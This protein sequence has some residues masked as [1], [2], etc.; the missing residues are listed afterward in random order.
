MILVSLD[1]I[2]SN[3]DNFREK[4]WISLENDMN[5]LSNNIY[6]A[7]YRKYQKYSKNLEAFGVEMNNLTQKIDSSWAEKAW[8]DYMILF[9]KYMPLFKEWLLDYGYLRENKSLQ[10][11]VETYVETL[12]KTGKKP[13][14]IGQKYIDAY[15]KIKKQ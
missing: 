9:E 1:K 3:T 11:L 8:T 4:I 12:T 2:V 5:V 14:E 6:K 10:L 7:F 15:N 13:S